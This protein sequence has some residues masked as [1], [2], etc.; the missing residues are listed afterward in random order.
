MDQLESHF[1]LKGIGDKDASGSMRAQ[2]VDEISGLS[3]IEGLIKDVSLD[4]H[5]FGREI[6]ET[7]KTMEEVRLQLHSET[8]LKAE[9]KVLDKAEKDLKDHD[10]MLSMADM[11]DG[12]VGQSKVVLG[13]INELNRRWVEIPDT[14]KAT[15]S[16]IMSKDAFM[17]VDSA[18]K[19]HS[20]GIIVSESVNG[21]IQRLEDIPD[22]VLALGEI[23]KAQKKTCRSDEAQKCYL[24]GTEAF[25]YVVKRQNILKEIPDVNSATCL[26]VN[27]ESKMN[28]VSKATDIIKRWRTT[29]DSL[30]VKN[31][32]EKVID[33]SLEAESEI[34]KA[35]DSIVLRK[36]I[37]DLQRTA[38]RLTLGIKD[39]QQN[40]VDSEMSI[41]I[42][43][44][45]RDDLM[46]SVTTCP[47]TLKPVSKECLI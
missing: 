22:T 36:S 24:A 19:L 21:L 25:E 33:K 1:M 32:R 29:N 31:D 39:L 45:Q 42:A 8:V 5:R 18:S 41:K 27:A 4:H 23:D 10:T 16:L 11:G 13:Q 44:K 43:E 40:I 14:L 6:K 37:E 47:L 15:Q 20:S 38:Q 7:E 17:I 3:G 28:I 34:K 12:I 46:S 35:Q 2:I 26:I 30:M 9:A